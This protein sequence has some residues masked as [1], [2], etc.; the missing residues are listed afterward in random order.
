MSIL[1]KIHR[2]D[3]FEVRHLVD[4]EHE[5]VKAVVVGDTWNKYVGL[6]VAIERAKSRKSS[7]VPQSMEKE[8]IRFIAISM[9]HFQKKSCL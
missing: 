9:Q 2:D 6:H 1:S 7:L 3:V 5:G 8:Y 4:E